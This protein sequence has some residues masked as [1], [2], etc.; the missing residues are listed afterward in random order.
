M[1]SEVWRYNLQAVNEWVYPNINN[2]VYRAGFAKKQAPYE[3][4][5]KCRPPL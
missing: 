3:E 2:G 5:F 4:A 1:C